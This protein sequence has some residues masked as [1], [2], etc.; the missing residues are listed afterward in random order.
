MQ[1]VRAQENVCDVRG[2]GPTYGVAKGG[3]IEN[4]RPGPTY[5]AAKGDRRGVYDTSEE[6]IAYLV[7]K[8]ISSHVQPEISCIA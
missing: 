7:S 2:P 3:N 8:K 4:R 6:K 5:G 1:A